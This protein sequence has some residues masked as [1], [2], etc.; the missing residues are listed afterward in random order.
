MQGKYKHHTIDNT[1]KYSSTPLNIYVDEAD[2][3]VSHSVLNILSK[4]RQH[5]VSLTL[6]Q[7][8]PGYGY[9]GADK[10]QLFNNTAVKFATGEGQREVLALMR[11]PADAARGL[12][13]GQFIGRWGRDGEPFRLVV[14][15]DLADAGRA[16]TAAEWEEVKAFQLGR[17]YIRR[18]EPAADVEPTVKPKPRRRV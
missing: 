4:L 10:Y 18:E 8:T 13:V 16:M 14:R 1:C 9:E 11:A 7:Q 5:K 15:R 17:Y 2:H 12:P 3:F 6:T